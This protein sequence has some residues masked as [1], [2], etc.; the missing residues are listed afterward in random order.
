MPAGGGGLELRDPEA[1]F[2]ALSAAGD[3]EDALPS[4]NGSYFTRGL[5]RALRM[6]MQA[7]SAPTPRYLAE[8]SRRYI[9]AEVRPAYR[10]TPR[11]AGNPSLATRPLE[12]KAMSRSMPFGRAPLGAPSE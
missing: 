3:D 12:L 4:E 7:G 9:H 10:Y 8:E 5:Y 11:L 2:L 6:A 1:N